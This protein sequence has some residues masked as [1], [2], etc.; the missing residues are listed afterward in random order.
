MPSLQG[1]WPGWGCCGP[2]WG[3]WYPPTVS[4]TNF[5]TGS[6][7]VEMID[8]DEQPPDT[9]LDALVIEWSAVLNGVLSS[10]SNTSKRLEDGVNQMFK[11]SQ[12]LKVGN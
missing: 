11:Q 7:F 6:V 9:D 1:G 2:G 8:P 12:Y 10:S 4:V 5:Q 3:W